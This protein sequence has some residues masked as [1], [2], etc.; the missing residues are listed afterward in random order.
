[1][2]PN[3]PKPSPA[4]RSEQDGAPENAPDPTKRAGDPS[5][6]RPEADD[7]AG[8]IITGTPGTPTQQGTSTFTVQGTNGDGQPL[9]GTYSITVGP[10]P[11]PTIITPNPLEPGTIGTAYAQ[12]LF[13]SGGI[14]PYT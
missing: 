11:P 2:T 9:R 14:G 8:A 12:N 10:A 6:G 1:M 3:P 5:T 4:R 7:E 13:V